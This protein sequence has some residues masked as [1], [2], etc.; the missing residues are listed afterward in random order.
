MVKQRFNIKMNHRA[1]PIVV[2]DQ[3]MLEVYGV[4]DSNK[5]LIILQS[6]KEFT[7]ESLMDQQSITLYEP[8]VFKNDETALNIAQRF[9]R[10]QQTQGV[11]N[12]CII[13]VTEDKPPKIL[14]VSQ[15]ERFFFRDFLK[16]S[17]FDIVFLLGKRRLAT[18]LSRN[19]GGASEAGAAQF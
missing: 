14:T 5:L 1:K 18:F 19:G 12:H 13:A 6:R 11:P 2:Y 17:V 3:D 15:L 8:L 4:L 7:L 10:F 9:C 16:A